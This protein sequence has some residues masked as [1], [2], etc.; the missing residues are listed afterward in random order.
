MV[1]ISWTLGLGGIAMRYTG[2]QQETAA[3][4]YKESD[5]GA[6]DVIRSRECPF[7]EL[8]SARR[9]LIDGL[10]LDLSRPSSWESNSKY[11]VE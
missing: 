9:S 3:R 1:T 2:G 11:S 10:F 5:R 6:A 8:L 4:L 7:H